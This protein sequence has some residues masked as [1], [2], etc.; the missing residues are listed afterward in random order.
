MPPA[1]NPLIRNKVKCELCQKLHVD[2][3]IASA[4]TTLAAA[5]FLA[6]RESASRG[7]A[8]CYLITKTAVSSIKSP[9][10]IAPEKA[11]ITV[12]GASREEL[13][14][15]GFEILKAC[16]TKELTWPANSNRIFDVR[17]Y[18]PPG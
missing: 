3:P 10:D 15:T 8:I 9:K 18:A 1:T 5:Y 7:C 16:R 6:F 4:Y 14:V 13:I 17:L 11:Y 2:A 12:N